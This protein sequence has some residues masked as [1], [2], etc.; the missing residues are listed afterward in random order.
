MTWWQFLLYPFAV[1]YDGVTRLRN[2]TFAI[3]LNPSFEY[4]ANIISV[5]NLEVGGTGKSPMIEYLV[6]LLMAHEKKV[7]TLS[8]G[9]GRKTRG[10]RVVEASDTAREAGDEPLAFRQKFGEQVF[11]AVGEDRSLAIPE[12][13]ARRPDMDV[14]LL[15]DAYQHR[16]VKPSYSILLTTYERPFYL[17]YVLPSGRLREARIGADRCDTVIVTKCPG[18]L[19]QGAMM[20]IRRNIHVFAPSA[21]VYFASTGYSDPEPLFSDSHPPEQSVVAVSGIARPEL[22]HQHLK[23]NYNFLGG[24][25]YGDHHRY[26]EQDIES[27]IKVMTE[28]H[29]MLVTTSKDAVKLRNYTELSQFPCYVLPIE[30]VFLRDEEQ[31]QREI[32]SVLKTYPAQVPDH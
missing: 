7:A 24:L 20:E 30:P 11:V 4:Q 2:H 21:T 29:A 9:Y 8:R 25:A 3:G 10:F 22:F 16:T 23:A 12:I 13:L 6:K 5:G 15:D 18:D 26:S 1:L 31:F 19:G 32:I 14:I 27:I 28:E 17:D